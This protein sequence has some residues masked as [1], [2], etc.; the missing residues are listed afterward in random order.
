MD[1]ICYFLHSFD[2]NLQKKIAQNQTESIPTLTKRKKV[3]IIPFI[4]YDLKELES[5]IKEIKLKINDEKKISLNTINNLNNDIL[6]KNLKIKNLSKEQETL[7]TELKGIKNEIDNRIKKVNYIVSRKKDEIGQ[8]KI[9]QKLI[10]IKEKEIEFANKTNEKMKKEY[11]RL[12]KIFNK[13]DFIKEINLRK[14]L[15]EL[16]NDISNLE[17]NNRKLESISDQ[18]QYCGKHKNELLNNLSLLTN[19]YQ[20]EVKKK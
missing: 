11:E 16:N 6:T 13:N 18:H 4:K 12:I 2:L 17:V 3:K 10:K 14:E 19:A 5:K 15:H 8:G 7:I 20:F 1:L 9:L